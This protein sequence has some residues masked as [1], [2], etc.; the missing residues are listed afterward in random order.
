MPALAGDHV[1]VLVA[2]YELTGDSNSLNVSDKRDTYD[3]AAFGDAVHKVV[4]GRR[5][6]SLDHAG[7]L[8]SAAAASHPILKAT[9]IDGVVSVI[10]GQNAAPATGDPMFSLYTLQG[11]YT[12]LAE[13]G[14]YVP[15]AAMFANKGLSGGW[16][17]ALAVPISFTNS[18]NGAAVNNGA[19]SSNGGAAFLHILTAAATDTYTITIQG[20]ATGAFSG[21]QTTLATFSLNASALGSER[22][23]INGAIPQYTRWSAVRSG[24]AG[25]TVR[26]AVN[27][28]RF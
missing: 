10:L 6:L 7:Y 12:T 15:F 3:V 21:E 2:G 23:A 20:S 13:A 22:V 19:A 24:S 9:S 17:S 25:N 1:Q 16:G 18:T 14:K 8:N 5:S 28:V 26:I 27:L 4:L 11:K